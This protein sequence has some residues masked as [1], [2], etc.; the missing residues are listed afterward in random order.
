MEFRN[1]IITKTTFD[2][3]EYVARRMRDMDRKEIYA[4]RFTKD[5]ESLV[6]E[7]V[8]QIQRGLYA[9]CYT[10][11]SKFHPRPIAI[12]GIL[13]TS[14][15]AGF[16]N[17]FATDEWKKIIRDATRFVRDVV[18]ADCIKAGMR[19]VELRTLASWKQNRAWLEYL[20]AE[21]ETEIRGLCGEPFAQYAW[22][23]EEL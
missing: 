21:F 19:R 14:P 22:T 8:H 2:D 7:L 9:C 10:I 11:A 23:R 4:T 1:L 6:A 18:I 5:D 12:V 16:A 13:L 15:S 17:M 20:G 3:V